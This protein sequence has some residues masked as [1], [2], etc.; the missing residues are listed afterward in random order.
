MADLISDDLRAE[1]C[2]WFLRGFLDYAAGAPVED[3]DE[4]PSA[5]GPPLVQMAKQCIAKAE[6]I[7]AELFRESPQQTYEGVYAAGIDCAKLIEEL[8]PRPVCLN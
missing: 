6:P 5:C 3:T 4:I 1:L 2:R 7:L 8:G